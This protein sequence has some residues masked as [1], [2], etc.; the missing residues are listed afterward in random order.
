MRSHRLSE[1]NELHKRGNNSYPWLSK[2]YTQETYKTIY[3]KGKGFK[4]WER[5]YASETLSDKKN[6]S[7]A[8]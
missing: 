8:F 5:L 1:Y 7:N 6:R 4:K 3:S 2:G